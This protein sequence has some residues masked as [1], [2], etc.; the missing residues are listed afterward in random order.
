MS[1]GM[2]V[3]AGVHGATALP[4]SAGTQVRVSHYWPV[5]LF[6]VSGVAALIYQVCWQRLLFESV[7]V[8]LESVTIIVSTFMFGLG[9]GAL[10]GGELADRYPQHALHSFALIELIT[11]AFGACSPWLIHATTAA[12]VHSPL[13]V[14]SAANFGLLLVPTTLMGATLPILVSHV[15]RVFHNLGVSVGVLYF[16]NTLGAALGAFATGFVVLYYFGLAA[17]IYIAAGLNVVVSALVWLTLREPR[18]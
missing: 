16:S 14:I 8:D 2:N 13:V 18:V 7:G 3:D 1:D 15:V 6:L 17:T 11:G 12:T 5:T 10:L 4:S 9:L